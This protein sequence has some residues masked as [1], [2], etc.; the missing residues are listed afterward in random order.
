MQ[1]CRDAQNRNSVPR[2]SVPSQ[3]N[4]CEPG[5]SL[6]GGQVLSFCFPHAIRPAIVTRII[7]LAF[8]ST[9]IQSPAFAEDKTAKR[10]LQQPTEIEMLLTRT[11]VEMELDGELRLEDK[12]SKQK[13]GISSIP[14]K[15]KAIQDYYE[16]IAFQESRQ[17][18][19]AREYVTA[20]LENWVNGKS[21]VQ[22]LRPNCMQTRVLEHDGTWE[23]FC[24]G[25]P[26]EH[27]EVELLRSPINTAVLERILPK[28]PAKTN[29]SWT[30]SDEDAQS[31]LNLEAVH[32]SDFH[33]KIVGVERGIAKMELQGKLQATADS[34][35]TE[36]QI[37]GSAHIQLCS[38]GAIIKWLGV[39][40]KETR[41]I[42]QYRPGF[43]VTARIQLIR[44]EQL[45][46]QLVQR[47]ELLELIAQDD[48]S[49]WLICHESAKGNYAMYTGRNWITFLDGSEDSVLRLIDNNQSI[50]QCNISQLPK[51]DAG[52]HLTTEGLEADVRSALK[53]RFGEV[54]ETTEKLTASK[55]RLLRMEVSGT[56]EQ[57]PIHWIYA[58]LSDD[59]GRRLALVFTLAA[60]HA[61]RFAGSDLQI[62]DSLQF[63]Q[64]SSE[65][66]PESEAQIQQSASTAAPATR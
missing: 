1:G 60:E 21:H 31:I 59:S 19:S 55:L 7:A 57:I 44:Q 16:T 20:N 61:E 39:S 11:K 40:I 30:I 42:S 14:V 17:A 49:R 58:H 23:Q 13:A 41:E 27:R 29:S 45:D 51:L 2:V 35:P 9:L 37:H 54:L 43:S 47:A 62:L 66:N 10:L 36:I 4:P 6:S 8:A 3:I 5:D 18:A 12:N 65:G 24:P 25:Q 28:Q 48:P 53:D 63:T 38:Q 46:K 33:A 15:A 56:Q 22:K 34:V 26:L 50:A 32:Q 64:G 52:T